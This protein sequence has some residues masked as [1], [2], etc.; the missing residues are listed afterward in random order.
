MPAQDKDLEHVK[1]RKIANRYLQYLLDL[2]ESVSCFIE[3]VQLRFEA[4]AKAFDPKTGEL[5]LELSQKSVNSLSDAEIG[6]IDKTAHILRLSFEVG[7][8]LYFAAAR[9][10]KRNYHT[11]TLILEFP[12]YK[13][14]RRNALRIKVLEEHNASVTLEGE[15]YPI[16]DISA[17]GMSVLVPLFKE[18]LF[19]KRKLIQG[20]TFK[21]AS[22]HLL[23][24]L[25]LVSSSKLKRGDLQKIGFKFH[26]LPPSAD[27]MI[28]KEAYLHTHKIWSRWI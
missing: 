11:L 17:T 7:D 10:L 14:Q 19:L 13:L 8:V 23:V 18:E 26:G 4:Y 3:E 24:D 12:L 2:N 21:F 5:V 9:L 15:T 22:L 28:A 25:E 16:H 1:D 6:S 20:V 27:Q